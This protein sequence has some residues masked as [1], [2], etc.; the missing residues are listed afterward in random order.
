M[1]VSPGDRNMHTID[2]CLEV[3]QIIPYILCDL[4]VDLLNLYH[5][6]MYTVQQS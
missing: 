1:F 5:F 3:T 6:N 2:L 4:D